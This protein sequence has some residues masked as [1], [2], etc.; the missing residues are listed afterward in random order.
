MKEAASAEIKNLE[1][2]KAIFLPLGS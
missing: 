2:G 1:S